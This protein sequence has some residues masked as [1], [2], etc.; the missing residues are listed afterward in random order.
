VSPRKIAADVGLDAIRAFRA[1]PESAL[2]DPVVAG[3]ACRYALQ[4]LA[5]VAPGRAV[6]VRVPP[7]G[8]VQVIEGP[9]HT[10]GTPPAVIE[11]TPRVWLEVVTGVTSWTEAVSRGVV[12]SSG[13]RANLQQWL[14]LAGL[15]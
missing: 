14:P 6:E 12:D 4:V 15:G 2:A 11:M 3:L 9:S 5:S 10:R 7:Y 8:A 13:H 1:S